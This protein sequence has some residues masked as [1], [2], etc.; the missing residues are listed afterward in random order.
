MD[1]EKTYDVACIVELLMVLYEYEG[2]LVK[3]AKSLYVRWA[4]VRLV[5]ISK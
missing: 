5:D 2:C 3:G 1:L 4:C